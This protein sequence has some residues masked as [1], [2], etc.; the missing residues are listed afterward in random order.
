MPWPEPRPPNYSAEDDCAIC[1]ERLIIP[2][3]TGETGPSFEDYDRA[4]DGY[5][6]IC[7]IC[8]QSTLDSNG[9]LIVDVMNEGGFSGGIDLGDILDRDR[10][11]EEQ[12]E[13]WKK[14]QALLSLCQVGDFEGAE[15]LL[16][17]DGADP[18]AAYEDGTTGL[19]MAALNNSVEWASLLLRYG[20]NKEL[21]TDQGQTALDYARTADA[22]AVIDLLE[23]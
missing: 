18:N 2:N 3:E 7:P 16:N 9:R 23:A 11:E 14:G 20:A 6:N 13:D 12:P 4:Q 8:R 17:D 19:H 1:Y 10:W 21:K 22:Q 5:R 15:E